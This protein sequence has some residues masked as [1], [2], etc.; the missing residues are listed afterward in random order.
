MISKLSRN[1]KK[2]KIYNICEIIYYSNQIRFYTN[3]NS[4]WGRLLHES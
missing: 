2:N 3:T 1:R 4:L